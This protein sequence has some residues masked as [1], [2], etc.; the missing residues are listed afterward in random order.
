MPLK[1][2]KLFLLMRLAKWNFIQGV[3]SR[4]LHGQGIILQP[5][6]LKELPKI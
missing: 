4:I 3:S 2:L 6:S 5:G 1:I